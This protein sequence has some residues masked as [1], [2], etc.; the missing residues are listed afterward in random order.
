MTMQY[1]KT[2]LTPKE[3][4]SM[5]NADEL[6]EIHE[7]W[8]SLLYYP[9]LRVSEATNVRVR[10]LNFDDRCVDVWNGKGRSSGTMQKAPCD[11]PVLKRIKR[12]CEHADL[13]P[14]DYVMFSR[15]SPQTTRQNV[16]LTVGKVARNAG[17]DKKIGTHTFRRSRAE[18][19]LDAGVKLEHVSKILRHKNLNTTMIYLD[20][21]INDLNAA[22]DIIDDPM[23]VL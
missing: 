13:K 3:M 20:I 17:I 14:S 6:P 8:M 7:V 22:I 11:L 23:K 21:S 2:W 15:V 18:H 10:D 4:K 9:A 12:Y 19:L 5:F 1:S 16:Y